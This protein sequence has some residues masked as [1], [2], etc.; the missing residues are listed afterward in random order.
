M[1]IIPSFSTTRQVVP[2]NSTTFEHGNDSLL[3]ENEHLKERIDEFASNETNL[4]E[5]NE[6]LQR[7]IQDLTRQIDELS[8]E[9]RTHSNTI[10][11]SNSIHMEQIQSLNKELE[12]LRKSSNDLQEKS[13]SE[14]DE[15]QRI[16]ARLREDIVDLDKT[17]QLYI[18]K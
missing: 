16:I 8:R 14:R 12:Q 10:T 1:S 7:Q 11:I 3:N 5:V 9:D 13:R 15:F 2:H 17:K 4:I 6:D 18:G